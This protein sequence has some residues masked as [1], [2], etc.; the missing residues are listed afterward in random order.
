MRT[1]DFIIYLICRAFSQTLMFD[2]NTLLERAT[3]PDGPA[4]PKCHAD[5]G[6]AAA[7]EIRHEADIYF[8]FRHTADGMLRFLGDA[9]RL[10]PRRLF[11]RQQRCARL[12][13]GKELWPMSSGRNGSAP[14]ARAAASMDA[15]ADISSRP[16]ARSREVRRV[17]R[18]G[19]TSRYFLLL[20][21]RAI[22]SIDAALIIT[23]WATKAQI[24]RRKRGLF[25]DTT[26]MMIRA[27]LTNF[28]TPGRAA[29]Q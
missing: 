13:F 24:F 8:D 2:F 5:A 7:C 28:F 18:P 14:L 16:Q 23:L 20:R 21:R 9:R 11:F 3:A 25:R 17:L 12:Y 27:G 10:P 1:H 19:R 4:S 26:L 29:R 22:S 6:Q 15:F